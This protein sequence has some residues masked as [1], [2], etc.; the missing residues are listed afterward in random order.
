CADAQPLR[1]TMD[2]A[3]FLHAL[4]VHHALGRVDE[5]LHQ[6]DLVRTPGENIRFAPLG[7]KQRQRFMQ[8][9]RICIFE[10]LHYAI[11][12][13]SAAKTRRGVSGTRGALTPMAFATAFA[14]AAMPPMA[15]GSPSPT[16]P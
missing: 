16:T 3:Q 8:G 10:G 1:R 11:L 4:D 13:S 5:I 7:A 15:H 9:C 6:A 12:L 14:M 2:P